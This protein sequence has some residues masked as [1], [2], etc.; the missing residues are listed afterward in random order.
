M[1]F[2][3]E[4]AV[5]LRQNDTQH[6]KALLHSWKL[7][8]AGDTSPVGASKTSTKEALHKVID[9]HNK[10]LFPSLKAVVKAKKLLDE[11]AFCVT[12]Y[13]HEPTK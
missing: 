9:E 8:K 13:Q 12:G 2:N 11:E 10:G 6:V 7:V 5:S 4:C 1:L 3:G